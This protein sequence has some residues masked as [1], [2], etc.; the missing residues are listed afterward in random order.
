MPYAF[1]S[2]DAEE[3]SASWRK[4]KPAVFLFGMAAALT[5][6]DCLL[7]ISAQVN[8]CYTE[9]NEVQFTC[10]NLRRSI[11]APAVGLDIHHEIEIRHIV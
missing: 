11:I 2:E 4:V 10:R 8:T 9:C 5:A 1:V 7:S 3:Q 6:E